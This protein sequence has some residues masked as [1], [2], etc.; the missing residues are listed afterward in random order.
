MK[1]I[2]LA[3]AHLLD[4]ADANYQ[5]LLTFLNSQCSGVRTLYLLGDIFEFWVGYKSVVFS[6]YVPLLDALYRLKSA[7]TDIVYIEGN[8]DFNLGPYFR[9]ILDCTIL[10]DGGTVEI[11]ELKVYLGHGDLVNAQDRRYRAL[12]RFLRSRFM[13]YLMAIAPPDLTWGIARWAGRRSKESRT[14][15]PRTKVPEALLR[16][17][18]VPL[19]AAGHQAVITGHY[20]SPMIDQ[21]DQGTLVALGDWITQFSYAVYQDGKF[22]LKFF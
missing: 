15:R 12:R 18:A 22:S 6:P 11:D 20:H 16:A 5:R 10:P 21:T 14:G 4:P 8:H 17:H 2:F 9:E 3:D 1:D 7:G 13:R 19:F